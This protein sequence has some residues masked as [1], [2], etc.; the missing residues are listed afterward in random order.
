MII[1]ATENH[2]S[3]LYVNTAGDVVYTE[4]FCGRTWGELPEA[5]DPETFR[6]WRFFMRNNVLNFLKKEPQ[7]PTNQTLTEHGDWISCEPT[8]EQ[9]DKYIQKKVIFD[10]VANIFIQFLTIDT[11]TFKKENLDVLSNFIYSDDYQQIKSLF[12]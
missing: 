10:M 2:C 4:G 12:K 5:E 7:Y 9:L 6:R 3:W 11:D 8:Q 1:T